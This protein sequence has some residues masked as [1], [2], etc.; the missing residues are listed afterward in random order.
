VLLIFI[1]PSL[2]ISWVV[3][4]DRLSLTA[5]VM[6]AFDA[7]FGHFG[8]RFMTPVLGIMLIAAALGG[9]LTWLA[10][11][12]KGLLLI[13]RAHGYLP[14]FLTRL[15]RHGVQQN[16]LVAQGVFTTVIALLYAFIPDVSSAYWML[17]AIT[18]QV[19]LIMYGLMFVTAIRLRRNRPD[20]PR[21]YRAPALVLL[22]AVG[23]LASVAAFAIGF[24]PPSQFGNGNPLVYVLIIALGVGVVGLGIPYLFH[25]FRRPSW[26]IVEPDVPVA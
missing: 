5:G 7:F 17:S 12:S 6:Q 14:P 9:M 26:K 21:G 15:N 8:V 4:A 2:V 20:H 3:P 11:P 1:I 23:L 18:T 22:S 19:Y 25:R 10:G 16:I 24:V 13:G